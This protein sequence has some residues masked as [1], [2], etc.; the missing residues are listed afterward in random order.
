MLVR[1]DRACASDAKAC[2]CSNMCLQ[3]CQRGIHVEEQSAYA[4]KVALEIGKIQV[5][6]M[7][8]EEIRH[9]TCML[10]IKATRLTADTT[11][12]IP[13][14]VGEVVQGVLGH[15]DNH[16]PRIGGH[17][18]IKAV[19]QFLQLHRM[20]AHMRRARTWRAHWYILG[21]YLF[22]ALC[23]FI[24]YKQF[25]GQ[26]GEVLCMASSNLQS[27]DL[28]RIRQRVE[29]MSAT[30]PHSQAR[31]TCRIL[32]D[33]RAQPAQGLS[34]C[35]SRQRNLHH[36]LSRSTVAIW[37]KYKPVKQSTSSLGAMDLRAL[38]HSAH[39]LV[40]S[41]STTSPGLA[42]THTLTLTKANQ[43]IEYTTHR[44]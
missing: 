26:L 15:D 6:C 10:S 4:L 39:D 3:T 5:A 24:Q 27:G 28:H 30:E 9:P 13:A 33:Q 8:P 25:N 12:D 22:S 16:R 18:A 1:R 43:T 17:R 19:V 42:S 40:D 23:P 32:M 38:T 21:E 44:S 14:H 7:T 29:R 31:Q 2:V 35:S 36:G 41:V 11:S 37:L 34:S 20:P